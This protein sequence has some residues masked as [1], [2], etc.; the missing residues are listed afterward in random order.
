MAL[1]TFN[2]DA[3]DVGSA[4]DYAK[5]LA[6]NEPNN[7]GLADPIQELRRRQV[8]QPDVR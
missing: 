7:R 3:G 6:R 5:R 4:L 1:I 8:S 2:R